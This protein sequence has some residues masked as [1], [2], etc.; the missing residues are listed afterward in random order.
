MFIHALKEH[1]PSLPPH[2]SLRT[3]FPCLLSHHIFF[4]FPILGMGHFDSFKIWSLAPYFML[5]YHLAHHILSPFLASTKS[6]CFSSIY[7]AFA[8]PCHWSQSILSHI[9]SY[10]IQSNPSTPSIK[11]IYP[12]IQSLFP[13]SNSFTSIS[14]LLSPFFILSPSFFQSHPRSFFYLHFTFIYSSNSP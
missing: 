4:H 13:S 8:L 1:M 11:F 7:H 14:I 2:N 9:H 12:L 5:P 3:I 6:H 10:H